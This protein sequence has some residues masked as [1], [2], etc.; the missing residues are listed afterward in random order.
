MFHIPIKNDGVAEVVQ[1]VKFIPIASKDLSFL[2]IRWNFCL[3]EHE[4]CLQGTPFNPHQL[5]KTFADAAKR[6][7]DKIFR[8]LNLDELGA[9]CLGC[10]T[11]DQC[12]PFKRPG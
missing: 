7:R 3:M 6:L 4:K 2:L 5:K 8:C 9:A 10:A 1:L 11:Q 12:L